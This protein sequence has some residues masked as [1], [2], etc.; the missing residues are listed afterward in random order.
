V[1]EADRELWR[2]GRTNSKNR[3]QTCEVVLSSTTVVWVDLLG[4]RRL[5]RV[6]CATR[7]QVRRQP[8]TAISVDIGRS[9]KIDD[10]SVSYS[11][12]IACLRRLH[13]RLERRLD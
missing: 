7:R 11:R 8:T 13:S 1:Q 4:Q 3:S 6:I 2:F 5:R 10:Q 9:Q 12:A